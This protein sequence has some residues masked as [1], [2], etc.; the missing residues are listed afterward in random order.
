MQIVHLYMER[1]VKILSILYDL[2]SVVGLLKC[3]FLHLKDIH[4]FPSLLLISNYWGPLL[5]RGNQFVRTD[6]QDQNWYWLKAY[7]YVWP[8]WHASKQSALIFFKTKHTHRT[9]RFVN[10]SN[11]VKGM[12][13][14]WLFIKILSNKTRKWNSVNIVKMNRLK[15]YGIFYTVGPI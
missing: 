14:I 4:L 9:L 3:P 15:W 6:L 13:W 5:L 12:S 7:Q 1:E 8:N 2:Q 11:A 10:P